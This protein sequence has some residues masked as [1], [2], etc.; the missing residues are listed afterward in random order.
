MV[1]HYDVTI[2]V[3][4]IL[5]AG[6]FQDF[7]ESATCFCCSEDVSLTGATEGDE[8]EISGLVVSLQAQGHEASLEKTVRACPARIPHPIAIKPQKDGAPG[9]VR[10]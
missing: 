4:Q 8:V 7:Y 3:E 6:L 1:R 9:C 5:L 2:D 10:D